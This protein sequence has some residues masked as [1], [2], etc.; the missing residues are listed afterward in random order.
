MAV[1]AAAAATFGADSGV[2]IDPADFVGDVAEA[3]SAE[4]HAASLC[5]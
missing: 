1:M 4:G 2:G 3:A 5:C